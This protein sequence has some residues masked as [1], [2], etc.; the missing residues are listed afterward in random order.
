MTQFTV[1]RP[2]GISNAQVVINLVSSGTP[3]QIYTFE[4]L[5]SALSAGTSRT[6]KNAVVCQIVRIA[7]RRLLKDFSRELCNVPGVGFRLAK[8]EEHMHL[9]ETRRT[10]ADRQ[11]ERGLLSLKNVRWE[12]MDENNRQAHKG[13][14]IIMQ[15]MHEQ[16]KL[17]QK[18][19]DRHEKL[20]QSLIGTPQ[21]VPML[22]E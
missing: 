21:Q 12:E 22:T 9:A 15:G 7:N 16:M 1:T 19:Q 18:T 8:A 4:E 5:A 14:L 20:I 13:T 2:G 6:Y 11:L 10:K 17:I 3:D